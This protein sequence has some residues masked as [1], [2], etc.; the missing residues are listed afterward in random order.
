MT[1]AVGCA[2]VGSFSQ[3]LNPATIGLVE[4]RR[5]WCHEC[6]PEDAASLAAPTT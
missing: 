2:V 4:R 3:G 1:D 5:R 6:V